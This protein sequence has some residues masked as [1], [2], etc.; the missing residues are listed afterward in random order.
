MTKI[1][2]V[3]FLSIFLK[4]LGV[5]KAGW[6]ITLFPLWCTIAMSFIEEI[7]KNKKE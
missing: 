4:L 2:W 3:I 7:L 1:G 6:L 5:I